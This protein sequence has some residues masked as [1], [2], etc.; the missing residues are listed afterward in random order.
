MKI[1]Y[2]SVISWSTKAQLWCGYCRCPQ[3]LRDITRC[4]LVA[5]RCKIGA[6]RCKLG[7][8]RCKL[9]VSRCKLR[10]TRCKLGVT[11]CKLRVTSFKQRAISD[12][13]E[14]IVSIDDIFSPLLADYIQQHTHSWQVTACI[15]HLWWKSMA[16][17]ESAWDLS[18]SSFA[19]FCEIAW[20][21][22]HHHSWLSF[23]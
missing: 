21:Q 17:S 15:S 12:S 6:T 18:L 16:N 11:R 10:V 8:T 3:G 5:T 22:E 13:G 9:G 23:S 4:K 14:G 7:V 1:K 2:W 20:R 19:S